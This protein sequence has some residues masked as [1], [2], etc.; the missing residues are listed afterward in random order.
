MFFGERKRRPAPP[1][2]MGSQSE[3]TRW[4]SVTG[5]SSAFPPSSPSLF[6]GCFAPHRPQPQRKAA[7]G[8]QP[9]PS[10]GSS[11]L[12]PS[13]AKNMCSKPVVYPACKN[14]MGCSS[15]AQLSA[16][17]SKLPA[18]RYGV[19]KGRQICRNI[20]GP[21]APSQAAASSKLVSICRKPVQYSSTR[22]GWNA[23]RSTSPP[24]RSS[25]CSASSTRYCG[26]SSACCGSSISSR[27][28]A[29]NPV[30]RRAAAAAWQAPTRPG[31]YK[32]LQKQIGGGQQAA[33][34]VCEKK[35]SRQRAA[36][37]FCGR[38]RGFPKKGKERK[39]GK[40]VKGQKQKE[41]RFFQR[42]PVHGAHPPLLR[43]GRITRASSTPPASAGTA[44]SNTQAASRRAKFMLVKLFCKKCCKL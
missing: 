12:V 27:H 30:G 29:Q 15:M 13:P 18:S 19:S 43:R 11:R 35:R 23:D 26:K 40:Q 3:E 7:W 44:I 21:V 39:A 25:R 41:Q 5:I 36:I 37:R 32:P 28:S 14:V 10:G 4:I 33:V 31:R 8:P 17:D 16:T 24:R 38:G 34:A 9:G 6:P 22:N 2:Y 1:F 42:I 20:C